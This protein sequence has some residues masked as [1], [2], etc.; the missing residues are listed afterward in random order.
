MQGRIRII[1]SEPDVIIELK[2]T[3]AVRNVKM[4][5]LICMFIIQEIED[6][7]VHNTTP[8]TSGTLQDIQA[9]TEFYH[10]NSSSNFSEEESTNKED[11]LETTE[12]IIDHIVQG[13][14][15][16][17]VLTNILNIV[18]LIKKIR[19]GIDNLERGATVGLIALAISDLGFC[20]FS[21]TESFVPQQTML[22]SQK[23]LSYFMT[24]YGTFAINIFIKMSTSFTV[25]LAVGRY[26]AVCFPMKAR[27]YMRCG[28]TVIA[29][30]LSAIFWILLHL[31]IL[32]T[33][34]LHTVDCSGY[35]PNLGYFYMLE[36]S[37]EFSTNIKLQITMTY[38][39]AVVGFFI[40]VAIL[41]YCNYKL[42]RSLQLSNRL[43][44]NSA[45]G[46]LVLRSTSR[47]QRRISLTLIGIV[48]MFF[49]LVCPSE[50]VHLYGDIGKLNALNRVCLKFH[51]YFIG[52]FLAN[53]Q[54]KLAIFLFKTPQ[55][56]RI[57][58]VMFN[59]MFIYFLHSPNRS[60]HS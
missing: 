40:P 52:Y 59:K 18:I 43:R 60:N 27:Q 55:R 19:E 9:S 21:L 3:A 26:F 58:G 14:C 1:F 38:I 30:I 41:G 15:S 5:E 53:H 45:S 50:I 7:T 35:G 2:Q 44:R 6:I 54:A 34:N 47:R 10:A 20:V 48:I 25:V 49:I 16:F 8:A 37:G 57:F 33:W 4:E 36:S 23:T 29:I 24:L 28:H 39:W 51:Y 12:K 32:W 42:V 31:P 13:L 56:K 22:F 11:L 46:E 17:G